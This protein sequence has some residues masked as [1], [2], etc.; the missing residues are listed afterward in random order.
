MNPTLFPDDRPQP[1][2]VR[3]L[4][5]VAERARTDLSDEDIERS[6]AVGDEGDESAV[7]RDR[8]AEL[9]P[10]ELGDLAEPGAGER[11]VAP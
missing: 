6:A 11:V 7:G 10:F 8:G 5:Q 3:S 9:G 4:R 2:L 1:E